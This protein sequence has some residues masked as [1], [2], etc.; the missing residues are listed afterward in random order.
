MD[1]GHVVDF[2]HTNF[3]LKESQRDELSHILQMQQLF[4]LQKHHRKQQDL[5]LLK[6]HIL[7]NQKKNAVRPVKAG[8]AKTY[9]YSKFYRN[10]WS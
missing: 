3:L 6:D 4:D 5:D 8:M 9:H 7:N 10:Q 1:R 2:F